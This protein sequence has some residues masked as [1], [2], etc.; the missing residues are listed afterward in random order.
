MKSVIAGIIFIFSSSALADVLAVNEFQPLAGG[1]PKTIS[2]MMEARAI[3][4]SMGGAV[5]I[6]LHTTGNLTYS[7][8]FEN[9]EAYGVFTKAQNTNEAWQAFLAKI[10]ADPS[11]TQIENYLLTSITTGAPRN[12]GN[13]FQVF[14]W[15]PEAGQ[16]AVQSLVQGALGAKPIHERAGA[17]VSAYT[18][19]LGNM[20]Y[21]MSYD[22]VEAWGKAADTPNP[23]FNA[24]M[25]ELGASGGP[26]GT[27]V[28]VITATSL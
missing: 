17:D 9:W 12:E 26:N 23:E 11:A 5:G 20:Y 3:H 25:Q 10:S 16:G 4:Q 18:D 15:E 8:A 2:Y 14:I 7:L 24:Y 1:T 27:M 22:D 28:R 13:V 21:I 19:L 6:S